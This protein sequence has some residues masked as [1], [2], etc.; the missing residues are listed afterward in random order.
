MRVIG[1]SIVGIACALWASLAGASSP[2]SH[3]LAEPELLLFDPVPMVISATWT[4]KSPLDAP[5]A[6]TGITAPDVHA[7]GATSPPQRLR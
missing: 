7:S 1:L 2:L 6:A 5:N 4:E 3:D